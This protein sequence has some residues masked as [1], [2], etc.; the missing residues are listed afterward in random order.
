MI[1]NEPLPL[2]HHAK[3]GITWYI[4]TSNIQETVKDNIDTFPDGLCSNSSM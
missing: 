1:K 2:S 3:Q 4:L